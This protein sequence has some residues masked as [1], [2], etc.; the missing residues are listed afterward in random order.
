MKQLS[1][2]KSAI[3]HTI[4]DYKYN[5]KHLQLHLSLSPEI[6]YSFLR[7]YCHMLDKGMNN[8]NFE[9]GHSQSV[10]K[11]TQKLYEKLLPIYGN[12]REYEWIREILSRF[13]EAQKIGKPSLNNTEPYVYSSTDIENHINFIRRRTSCRNFLQKEIPNDIIN[14]IVDIAIDAPNGCCRQ[15]VRYYISQNKSIVKEAQ[16]MIEGMTNFTNV[17]CLVCV[18]AE[19]SYYDIVDKNLR[20]ID[21]SL[22][23][24]NFLL[25]ASLFGVYGTICNFLHAS[26]TEVSRCKKLFGVKDSEDIIMYIAIGYPTVI[27]E[28]PARRDLDVFYKIV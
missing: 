12:D 14:K 27:P 2:I 26:D 11:E 21:S 9:S 16:S 28:K 1:L 25:G 19:F 15:V 7:M 6:E 22:S 13:E 5:L 10:F 24:E 18:A 20:Y 8:A 4:R 23:A 17:Q 3:K